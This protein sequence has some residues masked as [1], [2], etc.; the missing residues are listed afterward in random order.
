ME[1]SGSART[2]AALMLKRSQEALAVSST[3]IA[4]LTRSTIVVMPWPT[5]IHMV[6]RP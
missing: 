2:D 6:A 5:P 1:T 3:R 4:Q